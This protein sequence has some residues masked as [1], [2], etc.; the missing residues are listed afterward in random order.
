M[1]YLDH[2]A[3]TP[4]DEKVLSAML[5]FLREHHGNAA[6]R[7][8]A[9]GQRAAEAV[10]AAREQLATLINARP[11]EIIWTSGAT[12]ANNLAI[13]G[14]VG[15]RNN[16]RYHIITQATEHPA[17]LDPCQELERLGHEVTVLSV[18]LGGRVAVDAI[19]EAI[20]PNTVLVSVMVANNET[21]VIQPV[22]EIGEL[23]R[24]AGVL[25]HTDATQAVGKVAVDID[26]DCIDLLSMSA[27]KLYGPKGVGALYVR[28]K[29]PRVR[30]HPILFG[31]GHERGMRS[32]TINVP[33]VV[34]LGSA[35]EL[36]MQ[37]MEEEDKRSLELRNRLERLISDRVEHVEVN[38]DRDHRLS[39][40]TNLR[41]D[42]VEGEALLMHLEDIAAST[43]SACSTLS[44]EPSHVLL[45][46]GLSEQEAFSSVRFSLGRGN[47]SEDVDRAGDAVVS[48]TH[49]LR[50][51]NPTM[52]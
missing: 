18:D 39:H 36:A 41:F 28:S 52:P 48:A 25:F 5:P 2:N 37:V 12:E 40:V 26:A 33:G 44:M 46:M 19:R 49:R 35:C 16:D 27:H 9:L 13:F 29:S 3:T 34:G 6:S 22:R 8:H 4:L 30:L 7:N 21:G 50:E 11:K 43:G 15:A 45:A 47:T 20:Q 1:F 14:V 10:D 38:G 24:E 31:G 42:N 32:G 51:F 23:C 17:V